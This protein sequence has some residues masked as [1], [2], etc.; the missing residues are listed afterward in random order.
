VVRRTLLSILSIV[1]VCFVA[2]CTALP[3]PPPRVAD[4]SGWTPRLAPLHAEPDP[5]RGGRIV[6]AQGREV[7]LRGVNVNA[8]V[9][10]WRYGS[11]PTTFP[12]TEADA[13][14]IARIGW[15]AV[16]LL[17]SWS[18]VEPAPG[19]YDDTY[20]DE[21]ADAVHRLARHGVYS[22]IDFHQDA[23][24]PTLVAAP[25]ESCPSGAP[26]AF[27]WDG[28][29]AW[30]TLD[31]GAPRCA[32]GGIRELSPAVRA[33]FGAFWQNAPGPG[34]VG[35]RTR[36]AAMLGHV[37]ERFA[38]DRAVAGYD[39]MNEPNAFGG[40]EL[41]SL[42]DLSAEAIA[43]IRAGEAAARGFAH[44]VFVEPSILW[45]DYGSAAPPFAHDD[46]IVF[47]PHI[48]RGGLSPG[49]IPP[50]DFERARHDAAALGGAPVFVGEWGSGP[51][52]ADDPHDGYFRIHQALQ[53]QFRFSATLWTWRESCGDPHKAG[54]ARAGRLPQVWGEFVVDCRTNRVEGPRVA[55]VD[56]L[57]RAYV[58]AAPGRL[59]HL[60]TD[61]TTGTLHASG[62][63]AE[64][65]TQIVVFSPSR[66]D[67][68]AH[69]RIAAVGLRHVRVRRGA[70]GGAFVL[71]NATGGGWSLAIEPS[72]A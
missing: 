57:T 51:E 44:L 24:G 60:D 13:T 42:G 43:R 14:A 69:G 71:G 2:G 7:L 3:A 58:R 33:A 40:D 53:D 16:R 61:P 8:F 45:S 49:P 50:E 54:D 55:L 62:I 21:T 1:V 29:P 22:V 59:T 12:F 39:I 28:A 18:R 72:R 32:V 48:Y 38:R 65:G 6:D 47:A 37:A 31:G 5:V 70:D 41:H 23:W 9:E 10:Y 30:A 25:N 34:G 56:Q 67:A 27:G 64:R 46:Q 11:F 4:A 52:R 66:P 17:V 20:L 15:N 63:E 36:Y 26:P 19:R 35:I 68:L